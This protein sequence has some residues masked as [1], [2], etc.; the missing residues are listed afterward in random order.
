MADSVSIDVAR[1]L[2]PLRPEQPCGE[3][4]EYDPAFLA[5]EQ[6]LAGKPEVQYGDTL[7]EA[8][9]PDWKLV[10]DLSLQLLARSLDLRVAIA[11]TRAATQFDGLAGYVQGLDLLKGLLEQWWDGVHP[12][13][14]PDD[15]NDPTVRVNTIAAL[16]DAASSLRELRGVVLIATRAHGTIALG[17]VELVCGAARNADPDETRS[18][19]VDGACM[20]IELEPLRRLAGLLEAAHGSVLGIDALLAQRLGISCAPDLSPLA[21]TLQRVRD[22]IGERLAR[23]DVASPAA[24]P[25]AGVPDAEARPAGIA[26]A[27]GIAGR[28]DVVRMLEQINAYYARH[29]PSSPVPLLLSRA[30]R[31]VNMAFVDIVRELAPDGLDQLCKVGGIARESE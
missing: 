24:A 18:A 31:L 10:R 7:V 22:Y 26:A 20:D 3:N 17:E 21:K 14:D 25:A 1:L 27:G 13:L 16:A 8:Q 2:Q 6:A 28:E 9:P 11:L 30:Q 19:V 12:R 4:L 5:L 23:R 15:G 29:E